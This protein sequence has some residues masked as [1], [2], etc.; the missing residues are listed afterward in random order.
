MIVSNFSESIKFVGVDDREIDLFEGQYKVPDGVSYN[1]YVIF[2]EKIAVTDS[3]D[4]HKVSEWLTNVEN[5]LQGKTPDYLIVHHLEPDHAGGFLEFIKKYPDA[6][7]AASAKAL[8][9]IPQF[10]KLPEGTKTL[11]LKDGDTLSLG[12]HT[13]KFISAPM[14]H[15]PEVLLSYDESE[16]ILFSADAFGTFGLSGKLGDDWVSEARRYYINIVGKYGMQVQNVLKKLAGIEVKTICPLHGPVLTDNLSFYIDK[17]NTWSSYA[18]E[19][20]GVFVAYAGV[21]GHTAEAAKKLAESLREKGV[22]VTIMDL[23]RTYSSET[24]AQAFRYSHLAVCATTLDAG[25]FPAAEKFLTHIKAKNYCN[26][27]VGIVENGTWA[28]MAA[29]KMHEILD[30]LKNVTFCETTVTLKSSLDE[31]SAAKL[32]NL[33]VEFAKDLGK[34]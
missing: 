14:V 23:A 3:V 21:Y 6:T 30:T 10:V 20:Q 29:K 8:A 9:F 19:T 16:K 1:S 12:K 13:L 32:E 31:T 7:I 25:L 33:A 28:P 17:Y 15:W 11:T 4:A 26:R 5:A 18:P 27:K 24:V 34:A 22:D 2:D